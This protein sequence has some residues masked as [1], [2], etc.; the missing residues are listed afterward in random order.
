MTE[1]EL[2]NYSQVLIDIAYIAGEVGLSED[3]DSRVVNQTIISWANDFTRL[4]QYTDWEETDYLETIYSYAHDKVKQE[5]KDNIQCAIIKATL[6][7]GGS[8]VREYDENG[9]I[10]SDKWINNHGGVVE[11][12]EFQ[13]QAEYAAYSMGLADAANWDETMLIKKS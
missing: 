4:H 9:D 2:E 12:K 7:C 3:Q 8:A 5:L 10:P 1:I 13:T 6:I 11:S